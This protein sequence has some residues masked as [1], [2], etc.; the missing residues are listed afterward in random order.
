M[1]CSEH[2]LERALWPPRVAIDGESRV[3]VLSHKGLTSAR[4]GQGHAIFQ[5]RARTG[6]WK[7]PGCTLKGQE[8]TCCTSSVFHPEQPAQV[9]A[10][11]RGHRLALILSRSNSRTEK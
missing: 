6:A 11:K 1:A 9:S 5:S 2:S 3:S 10:T 8:V 7:A 4:H